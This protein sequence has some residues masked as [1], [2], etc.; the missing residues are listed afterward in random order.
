V[1]K[2]FSFEI[3]NIILDKKVKN[4]IIE[5]A[6]LFFPLRNLL[7]SGYIKLKHF[8]LN[9]PPPNQERHLDGT[10]GHFILMRYFFFPIDS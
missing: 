6:T 7:A 5:Q 4:Y 2:Y 10:L 1:L 9:T 3:N 8:F